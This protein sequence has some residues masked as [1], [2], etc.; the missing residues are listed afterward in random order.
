[1][2]LPDVNVL[3]YAM[4][5]DA[6]QHDEYRAWLHDVINGDDPFGMSTQALA[7]VIRI[8]T[9]PSAFAPPSTIAEALGFCRTVLASEQCVVIRPGPLHWKIFSELCEQSHTKGN[10]VQ[11]A[12]F[13]ALAIEAGCEWIT[14]DRDYSRFAGLRWR[15]PF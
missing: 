4:R 1:M 13:A 11:D 2:I 7:S 10:M 8:S 5:R 6:K 3:L 9:H 12:W 14:T 15:A